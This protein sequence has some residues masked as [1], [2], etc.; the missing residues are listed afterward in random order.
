MI[1][2][3]IWFYMVYAIYLC[4]LIFILIRHDHRFIFV[5]TAFNVFI[6]IHACII[7]LREGG[8]A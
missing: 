3:F 1:L 8:G 2:Y 7:I 4:G 5:A 6:Y